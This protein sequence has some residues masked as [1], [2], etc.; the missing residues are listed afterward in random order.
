MLLTYT[1][2]SIHAYLQGEIYGGDNLSAMFR[3]PL[4]FGLAALVLQLPFA[5]RKDI[6][7]RKEMKYGKRLRGG[8]TSHSEAV[9]R[10]CTRRRNRDQNQRDQTATPH[11]S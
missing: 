10:T 1:N 7:R 11:P 9:Q 4:L 2:K 8:R 6:R 3:L 5:I